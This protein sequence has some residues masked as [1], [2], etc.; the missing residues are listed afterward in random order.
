MKANIS[1]IK[2]DIDQ[3][4]LHNSTPG[5]GCTRFSYSPEDLAARDWLTKR[6]V[7]AGLTVSVD[8]IGTIRGRLEGTDPAALPVLVG[9]HIDTVV[10]G[11][12]FDGVLGVVTGLEALRVIR[13]Q[14]V[15]HKYPL[16]LIVFVEE[17]GPN[18][19]VPLAGSKT[20]TG[21]LSVDD[22][23]ELKNNNGISM[24]EAARTAGFNPDTLT[25]LGSGQIR[26][27]VELHVEQSVVLERE[28]IAVG[29]VEAVAGGNWIG[30][31][32][33]GVANHA[34]ATPMQ[35]RND[36]MVGAAL[37]IAAVEDLV[38][39]LGTPAT[40]GTVGRISCIPNAPNV[41]PSSV[42]FTIDLRDVDAKGIES[43]QAGIEKKLAEVAE[44]R[45]LSWQTKIL[46][47]TEPVRLSPWV[48]GEIEAAAATRNIPVRRMNS[49][50]LHD[51]CIM[52]SITEVG[53]IFVPSIGGRSHVPQEFTAFEDILKGCDVLLE[54]LLRLSGE[55]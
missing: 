22:L 18:F 45:D 1:R 14:E 31:E 21:R 9:S 52:T 13:E 24:Y 54:T 51:A 29:I 55:G 26:A 10:N 5:N 43:V 27:M 25:V 2:A 49:G 40:V 6:M 3:I 23:K 33:I 46:G 28:Q 20:L 44:C 42:S 37:V 36:P 11:G 39:E 4:A 34:G 7:E 15:A 50:A 48:V 35:Y 53:M 12:N 32:I 17:E 19:G 47:S 16:E 8:G 38:R 30:V 41:I